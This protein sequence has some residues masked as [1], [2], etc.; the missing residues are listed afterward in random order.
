MSIPYVNTSILCGNYV[1][2]WLMVIE[3]PLASNSIVA[4]ILCLQV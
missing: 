3:M 4:H 2:T 1:E